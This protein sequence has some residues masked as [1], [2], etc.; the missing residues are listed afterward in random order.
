MIC[1]N[2]RGTEGVDWFAQV[3][4]IECRY[5]MDHENASQCIG[6]PVRH[7]PLKLE[8]QVQILRMPT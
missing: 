4:R 1:P 7:Q 6:E 8:T 5:R 2:P 3:N